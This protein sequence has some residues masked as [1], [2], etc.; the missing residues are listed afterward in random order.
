MGLL[1]G[2]R[3]VV[4]IVLSVEAIADDVAAPAVVRIAV[5]VSS[6]KVV[7]V[8]DCGDVLAETDALDDASNV[9]EVESA[10][11]DVWAA[12]VL[13]VRS[14]VVSTT[15]LNRETHRVK[16]HWKVPGARLGTPR[17]LSM[18][19]PVQLK[20]PV[21]PG[22]VSHCSMHCCRSI[23]PLKRKLPAPIMACTS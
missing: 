15:D 21:Q 1:Y 14:V 5:L 22:A 3:V 6:A 18:P 17:H 12:V 23:R 13:A 4:P 16:R 19:P 20:I 2:A 9:V 7:A 8:V 10:A 11:V